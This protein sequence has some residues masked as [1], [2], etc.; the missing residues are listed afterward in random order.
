TLAEAVAT[1]RAG[2]RG[3]VVV[4]PP[5]VV[6]GEAESRPWETP[7][8]V[9]DVR[10]GGS[11]PDLGEVRGQHEARRALGIALARGHGLVRIGPAGAGK[12]LLAR[13]I[14]GLLPPLD[15][16]AAL[17]TTVIA[18]AAGE[19][20]ITGLRRRP[21]FRTPHHSVSYAGMVGGGPHL[22]PGEITLAN[23][24]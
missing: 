7:T 17:A 16:A 2:R 12:P 22:S 4:R 6:L 18:S 21:P 1:V 13:T 11:G 9:P 19:G 14:P 8:V 23:D 10:D 5:R 24:G 3:R 20:P 15:D